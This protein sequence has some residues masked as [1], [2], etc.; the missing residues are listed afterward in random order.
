MFVQRR[1]HCL[2]SL[3]LSPHRSCG[4][5]PPPK[6]G[7]ERKISVCPLFLLPPLPFIV[8][9]EPGIERHLLLPFSAL[10]SPPPFCYHK[11]EFE[12]TTVLPSPSPLSLPVIRKRHFCFFPQIPSPYFR[13]GHSTRGSLSLYQKVAAEGPPFSPFPPGVPQLLREKILLAPSPLSLSPHTG[14]ATLKRL[15]SFLPITSFFP[16]PPPEALRSCH[17]NTFF[18]LF[19]HQCNE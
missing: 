8:E 3:S 4:V 18:F 15:I 5:L 10:S 7:G 9:T 11:N 19:P 16:S 13:P 1:F 17:F 6:K 12:T 14:Q 2:P